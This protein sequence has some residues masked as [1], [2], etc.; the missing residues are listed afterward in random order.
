MRLNKELRRLVWKSEKTIHELAQESGL[1]YA[2]VWSFLNKN[3][4][5]TLDSA[6]RLARAAEVTISIERHQK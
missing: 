2:T 3:V 6:E 1:G 5:M 4:G